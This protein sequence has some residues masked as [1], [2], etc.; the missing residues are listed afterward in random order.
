MMQS[1]LEVDAAF[2]WFFPGV[3]FVLGAAVGSFLNVCIY[4]IPAGRSIVRP[5]STCACG[6]PVAW[7]DNIPVVSWFVL[8]GRAR[9][10]GRRFSFRYPAIELLTAVLFLLCWTRLPAARALP[11][12]LL[13]SV[14]ICATFIDL[15][16]MIIPDR[17]TIGAAVAG[18]LISVLVPGLHGFSSGAYF[19][20]AVRSL[21]VSMAG[22]LV[23]SGL[24]LWIALVAEVMLK[25]EAMGFGDVKFLGAIGSFL[26]WQGGVFSV[27]GG[28]II[29]TLAFA[30][31]LLWQGVTGRRDADPENRGRMAL[32]QQTPFGPMLAGGALVYLLW[33]Q[34]MVDAY[35]AAVNEM[36]FTAF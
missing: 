22:V 25:K 10:C 9:C 3:F 21:V 2:P 20:D 6:R 26:G 31:V 33:M 5:G 18:V 14:L 19:I 13:V 32:G 4:R 1:L 30:L 12:M 34:P 36:L 16:H 23:G 27:F 35:F 29:G 28:A 17:F 7:H 8:R 11:G 24:V 15:D